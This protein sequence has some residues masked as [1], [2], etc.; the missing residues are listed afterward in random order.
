M[1][2][3]V[4]NYSY[5]VIKKILPFVI[6]TINE[7]NILHHPLV[8]L[9]VNG[10]SISIEVVNLKYWSSKTNFITACT[11]LKLLCFLGLAIF[12]ARINSKTI[13]QH[14]SIEVCIY[15]HWQN[16]LTIACIFFCH[17]TW[18]L[19]I[20]NLHY[21]WEKITSHAIVLSKNYHFK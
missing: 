17:E 4:F 14:C 21:V 8:A 6:H 1:S 10:F 18:V 13:C 11:Y 12:V 16:A 20:H 3:Q 19:H 9:I 2:I 7:T 15:A 5:Q